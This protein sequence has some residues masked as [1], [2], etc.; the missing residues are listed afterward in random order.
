MMMIIIN[1]NVF[2]LNAQLPDNDVE[3]YIIIFMA[4]N[5]QQTNTIRNICIQTTIMG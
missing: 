1:N 5:L 4:N 2:N 3:N